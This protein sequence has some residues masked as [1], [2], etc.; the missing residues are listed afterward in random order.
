MNG[1]NLIKQKMEQIPLNE[2]NSIK[3]IKNTKGYQWE[4]KVYDNKGIE[5][6]DQVAKID[7]QLREKFKGGSN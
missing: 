6:I 3:L 1:R 2:T 5:M 4:I 7:S